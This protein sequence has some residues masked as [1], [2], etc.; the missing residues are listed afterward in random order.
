MTI[1]RLES[2]KI[3]RSTGSGNQKKIWVGNKLIKLN[4]KWREA[5]KEESA[6]ILADAF[7]LYSVQYIKKEYIVHNIKCIGCECLSYLN[8]G[9]TAITAIDILNKYNINISIN[10]SAIDYF[11]ICIY[12]YIYI[13]IYIYILSV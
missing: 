6:G 7:G 12:V 10:L 8:K 4:S 5:S 9:E 2:D 1:L 13:Y 11:N 3:F